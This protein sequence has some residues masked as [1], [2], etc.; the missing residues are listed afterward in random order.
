[1]YSS[2]LSDYNILYYRFDGKC[3]TKA[4]ILVIVFDIEHRDTL[5]AISADNTKS[6][7]R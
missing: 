4:N 2:L 3:L 1:M 5:V 7:S 6:F